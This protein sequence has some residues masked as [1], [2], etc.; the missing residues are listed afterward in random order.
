MNNGLAKILSSV[1]LLIGQAK[2][3]RAGYDWNIDNYCLLSFFVFVFV[4]CVIWAGFKNSKLTLFRI[5]ISLVL[6]QKF[7]KQFKIFWKYY[8]AKNVKGDRVRGDRVSSEESEGIDVRTSAG[9]I[10]NS[11]F[12]LCSFFFL[13]VWQVHICWMLDNLFMLLLKYHRLAT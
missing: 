9:D 8:F 6:N 3:W 11:W 1:L 7:K 4:F 13:V 10:W 5:F 12:F 2:F